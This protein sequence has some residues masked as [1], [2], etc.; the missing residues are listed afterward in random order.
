M[1]FRQMYL[2]VS[3]WVCAGIPLLAA[4]GPNLSDEVIQAYV[5]VE[6][7]NISP[8]YAD[9]ISVEGMPP[10]LSPTP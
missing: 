5:Q 4:C 1:K 6:R 8:I 9:D 3:L 2:Q 7:G 10:T